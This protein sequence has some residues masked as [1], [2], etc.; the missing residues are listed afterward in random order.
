MASIH[1]HMAEIR[2]LIT[3]PEQVSATEAVDTATATYESNF[4]QVVDQMEHKGYVDTGLEGQFREKVHEIEAAVG[5]NTP[6]IS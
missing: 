2:S 5:E 4:L 1:A 6:V 3:Q